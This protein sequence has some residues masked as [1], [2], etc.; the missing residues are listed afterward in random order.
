MKQ[1]QFVRSGHSMI[2]KAKVKHNPVLGI[3]YVVVYATSGE[4]I[5]VRLDG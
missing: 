1:L 3:P 2:V 4:R 5:V